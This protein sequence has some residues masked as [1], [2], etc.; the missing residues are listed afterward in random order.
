MLKF[1]DL[2]QARKTIYCNTI[3]DFEKPIV[4]AIQY[5]LENNSPIVQYNTIYWTHFFQ[6]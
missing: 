1:I 3:G 4:I 2:R 6:K 5:S